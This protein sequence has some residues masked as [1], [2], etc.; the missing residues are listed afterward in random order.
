MGQGGRYGLVNASRDWL[1]CGSVL[2]FWILEW[3]MN[4]Q[5]FQKEVMDELRMAEETVEVCT[6]CGNERAG[7]LSCCGEVHFVTMS[8]QAWENG[9]EIV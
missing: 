5:Q 2:C 6:Y 8:R 4:E 1:V 7:K 9:E 3:K